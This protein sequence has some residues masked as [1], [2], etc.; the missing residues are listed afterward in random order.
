MNTQAVATIVGDYL[1]TKHTRVYWGKAPATKVFP[2]VVFRLESVMDSYP[3]DDLY[4]NV[5]LYEDP[6]SSMATVETL[7]DAIDKDLNHKVFISNGTNLHFER[8]QR[9]SVDAQE[10]VG[11]Y[12]VNIRYV[13]RAYFN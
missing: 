11:A 1:S 4:V 12:L 13:V 7:A 6:A 10:L 8:E 2:Y 9:Q 3:S 5:D